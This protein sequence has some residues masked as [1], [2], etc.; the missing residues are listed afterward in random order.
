MLF[1]YACVPVQPFKSVAF[2]TNT[3]VPVAVGAPDNAPPPPK[4]KPGGT[5]PLAT[6]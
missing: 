1:V 4:L 5:V 2:T 6:A 3:Y